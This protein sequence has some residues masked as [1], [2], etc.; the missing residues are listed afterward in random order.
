[1]FSL[2]AN[3]LI[4]SFYFPFAIQGL[5]FRVGSSSSRAKTKLYLL[6]CLYHLKFFRL[7][8]ILF[9]RYW[10]NIKKPW[11]RVYKAGVIFKYFFKR[12]EW[13][14][15]KT[16]RYVIRGKMEEGNAINN[17]WSKQYG[18][19]S[20]LWCATVSDTICKHWVHP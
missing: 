8:I 12:I 14:A 16:L 11:Q 4:D 19:H 13:K 18:D 7:Q 5:W 3:K 17:G 6:Y 1:M 2:V 10:A 9:T 15:K 20:V